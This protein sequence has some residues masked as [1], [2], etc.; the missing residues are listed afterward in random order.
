MKAELFS[1]LGLIDVR[2]DII[3]NI[4]S[5]RQA[6][7]LFDD[8]TTDPGEW[9]LAQ[10]VEAEMKPPPYRSNIPAID[11]PFEDAEW[12]NA[13]TW[14]FRNWQASRFSDGSFGVWYGSHNEETTI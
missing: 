13:I 2:R 10:R 7:D 3:R 8:L 12:F 14:P 6:Q 5:L 4:V 9:I 1:R 11:R